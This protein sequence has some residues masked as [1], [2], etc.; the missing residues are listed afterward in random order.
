MARLL[1]EGQI[2]VFFP[3]QVLLVFA[4]ACLSA[5]NDHFFTNNHHPF[6]NG[7]Q[8]AYQGE[9]QLWDSLILSESSED[10]VS[11]LVSLID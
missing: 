8:L 5:R 6:W 2:K 3:S 1:D 11:L 9:I 10:C 7:E 4:C